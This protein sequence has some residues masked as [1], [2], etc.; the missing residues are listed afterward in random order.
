MFLPLR[1]LEIHDATD[2]MLLQL[3]QRCVNLSSLILHGDGVERSHTLTCDAFQNWQGL[4]RLKLIGIRETGNLLNSPNCFPSLRTLTLGDPHGLCHYGVE[5][6]LL[7]RDDL[8]VL[9]SC[10]TLEVLRFYASGYFFKP[11]TIQGK[12][13]EFCHQN[14]L[15]VNTSF[16][17][18]FF[19]APQEFVEEVYECRLN[20]AP[21]YLTGN[22]KDRAKADIGEDLDS[23]T[24]EKIEY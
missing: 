18:S 21:L 10:P 6:H 11:E 9:T 1:H 5:D 19:C 13:S 3:Q 8:G 17:F 23:Y 12:I 14:P 16:T 2:F 24:I 15:W 22:S 20:P 4:T 7:N